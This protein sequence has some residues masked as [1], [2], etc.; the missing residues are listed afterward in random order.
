MDFFATE[1]AKEPAADAAPLRVLARRERPQQE[2]EGS[3]DRSPGSRG[4]PGIQGT[5]TVNKRY[6]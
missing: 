6:D 1:V 3:D 5:Q 4:C 2:E